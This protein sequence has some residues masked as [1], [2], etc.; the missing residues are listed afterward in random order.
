MTEN[1]EKLIQILRDESDIYAALLDIAEEKKQI[2][3]ENKVKDLERAT[4]KEQALAGS[5]VKLENTRSKIV[6]DIMLEEGIQGVNTI[7][8]LANK[9]DPLSRENLNKEKLGLLNSI[10]ELKAV[11]SL[12]SELIEQSLRFIDLNL[13]LIGE[14]DDDG[15]YGKNLEDHKVTQKRNLFDAKV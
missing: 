6:E 7:S 10:G 3:I 11:N 14:R 2:I 1:I 5:L 12:N 4:L 13:S 15:R 9:L 8:E